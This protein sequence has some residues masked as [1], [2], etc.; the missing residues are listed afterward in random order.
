MEAA[1]GF[2]PGVKLLQ[3]LALPLGYAAI[4]PKKGPNTVILELL[5]FLKLFLI[6]WTGKGL[7]SQKLDPRLSGE[8][9]EGAVALNDL[10]IPLQ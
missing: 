3:S 6:A 7:D 4:R 5:R 10:R 2:E 8:D 9:E 1:P